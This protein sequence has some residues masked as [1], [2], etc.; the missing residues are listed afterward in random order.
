LAGTRSRRAT[1]ADISHRLQPRDRTIAVLLDD[2]TALTTDQI[3]AILFHSPTTCLN[4]LH[5]LRRL[6]FIA[7]ITRDIPGQRTRTC[8][9]PGRLS[10][11]LVALARGNTPPTPKA[12]ALRQDTVLSRY[13]AAHTVETNQFFIDLIAHSRTHPG[14]RLSRWWSAARTAAAFAGRIHPD[15]HGIWETND[16]SV[17]FY[18]EH[19][20]GT[21]DHQRLAAK[22]QPYQRLRTDGGPDYPILFSFPT[23]TRERHFHRHLTDAADH[24]LAATL[25]NLTIATSARDHVNGP[26]QTAGTIWRLVCNGGHRLTLAQLPADHGQPSPLNP[27][28]PTELGQEHG[29]TWQQAK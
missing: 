2:H 24:R 13:S 29:R 18:L 15:G 28:P 25:A 8:W 21:M 14:T 6:D 17:G 20:R 9:V 4:R 3:A 23:R 26:Y 16:R 7:R 5:T 1:L 19:D 22:L 10:A 27:T 12:V 11:R